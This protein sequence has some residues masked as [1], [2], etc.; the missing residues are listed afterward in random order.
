M[1]WMCDI[2]VKASYGRYPAVAEVCAVLESVVF[3]L[4][5]LPLASYSFALHK[6]GFAVYAVLTMLE[7][8]KE[9]L[10]T[11]Y[12]MNEICSANSHYR[13]ALNVPHLI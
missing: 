8:G 3:R 13:M 10:T 4:Q 11:M 5:A 9:G 7:P 1:W 6:V 12:E 2:P